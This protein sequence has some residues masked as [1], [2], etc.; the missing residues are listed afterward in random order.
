MSQERDDLRPA[1]LW[2]QMPDAGRRLA[3][4][5]MWND[6]EAAEQQVEAIATIARQMKFRAKTVQSLDV[7]RKTRYLAGIGN[8]SDALAARLVVSFHLTHQRPMMGAFL[9]A[10]AITH[11]NGLITEENVHAPDPAKLAEA[12]TALRASYPA[13]A[14]RLYFSTLV[15][16]DPDTWGGLSSTID[17]AKPVSGST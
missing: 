15:W 1:R 6:E 7:D 11:D 10:L 3:A 4:G 17:S 14:V 12:V 8:V 5:A 13:D 9:D 16:Q 2:K